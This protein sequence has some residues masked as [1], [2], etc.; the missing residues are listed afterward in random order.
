[1][2]ETNGKK[3]LVLEL[4]YANRELISLELGIQGYDVNAT[5]NT[6]NFINAL[7]DG[8]SNPDLII[9]G[10][11]RE[12]LVTNQNQMQ[13]VQQLEDAIVSMG[14]RTPP[15]IVHSADSVETTRKSYE[16]SPLKIA[17]FETK[18]QRTDITDVVNEVLGYQ[19]LS[20]AS[21]N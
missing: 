19:P 6:G 11:S 9:L 2:T 14:D 13:E 4:D 17:R 3:V 12:G 21:N 15:I 16:N 1:M 20:K 10:G 18:S 5:G 7:N 8:Y